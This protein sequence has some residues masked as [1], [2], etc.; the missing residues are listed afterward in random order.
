MKNIVLLYISSFLIM[1]ATAQSSVYEFTVNDING[2][3]LELSKFKGKKLLIVN[4]ASEC[5][6]T[7]QYEDLQALYKEYNGKLEIIGFPANNFGGQEPGTDSD[8]KSFCQKNYGVEFTMASK[9]SVK[10]D[11]IHP[12]F[13]YLTELENESFT[14]DIKWN[15]EK[16]L[17]DENGKF[18]A[19]YRSMTNPTSDKITGLL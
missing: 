2:E 8:I 15:F 10:G 11:D 1:T 17:I 18:I 4:T 12:L 14:G 16:F 19:R 6:F 9:V 3:K 7:P 5:G 13:K